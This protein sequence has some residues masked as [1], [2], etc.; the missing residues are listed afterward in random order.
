MLDHSRHNTS[1]FKGR[2][3]RERKN[4]FCKPV[5]QSA[6]LA[7]IRKI[8]CYVKPVTTLWPSWGNGF[9]HTVLGRGVTGALFKILALA[10]Q[11]PW[12]WWW[13]CCEFS[14]ASLLDFSNINSEASF[15]AYQ[16]FIV[17]T[18]KSS[19]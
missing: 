16:F 4:S 15:F 18:N 9:L 1:K 5:A 8:D 13:F 10:C 2:P 19:A 11:W 14:W 7:V 6:C 12:F 3:E 17:G